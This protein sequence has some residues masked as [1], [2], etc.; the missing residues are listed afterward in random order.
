[1]RNRL[2]RM[3]FHDDNKPSLEGFLRHRPLTRAGHYKVRRVK[4]IEGHVS[5]VLEGPAVWIPRENIIWV[6]EIK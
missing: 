3:H 2:V 4:V 1:M 5:H 6:Q